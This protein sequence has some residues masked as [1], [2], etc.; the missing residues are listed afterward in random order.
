MDRFIKFALNAIPRKY[1]IRFS[2]LFRRISQ[3]FNR[4]NNVECPV[5]G[6][7]YRKFLSYGYHDVRKNALCPKCLSLERHRLIWLFLK[8][9][10]GFFNEQL[11]VLHIA[12]EQCFEERFRKLTNLEYIT[13]DLDSPLADF[14]CD[15]QKM[16]FRDNE[17]DVV[18]CNHVLEHVDD[19]TLAMKEILRVMKPGA[20]AILLVPLNFSRSTTYEDATITSPK[21]RTKHFL[22]YDHK[23]LYGT[24]FPNRL[25]KAGFI[26]PEKNFLDEI[27]D[28]HRIRYAL[29]ESEFMFGYIKAITINNQ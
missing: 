24:D 9:K 21:E 22:Q 17:F 20:F 3:Y 10:T 19:D 12:P 28:E 26:V 7:R 29:P 15:V 16:P 13:A 25:K 6:S 27:D 14:I 8:E 18:I 11:K 4:G 1:L 5:C 2:Y 23:R